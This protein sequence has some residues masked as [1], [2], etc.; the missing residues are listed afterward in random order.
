MYFLRINIWKSLIN[1]NKNK[2]N[3]LLRI[4]NHN[5][6]SESFGILKYK[7]CILIKP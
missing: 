4:N 7:K 5:N 3:I 2:I 6:Y 1:L